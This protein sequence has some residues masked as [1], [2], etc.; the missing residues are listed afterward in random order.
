MPRGARTGVLALAL[1]ATTA[2][3]PTGPVAAIA[4]LAATNLGL[5]HCQYV[6]SVTQLSAGPGGPGD[7]AFTAVAALN[8][9]TSA[10]SLQSVDYPTY[11][12]TIVNATTG[13]VGI[14]AGADA[15]DASWDFASPLAP[16]PAGVTDAYTL[17][18]MSKNAAWTGAILTFATTNNAPCQYAAPCGDVVLSKAPVAD[19]TRQTWVV[20]AP[21]PAPA[22]NVSVSATVVNPAVNRRFMGCHSDYGFSQTPRG[23]TANLIYGSQF[24]AG[25]CAVPAW[26]PAIAGATCAGCSTG[27]DTA[28]SFSTRGSMALRL[29]AGSSADASVGVANRGLCGAGLALAAGQPYNA[30]FFIWSGGSPTGFVELRDRTT[31]ASLAKQTFTVVTTGPA[32]GSTWIEYTLTLTPSA[33][34]TCEGI[35][36]GSDPT[37][38]CGGQPSDAH[39]C[40]KCGGEFVIGL[41]TPGAIN[42]GH[43]TLTPGSW[44]LLQDKAGND[45]PVLKSGAAMLTAMGVTVM[46]SGGSVSQSMR[47]KDWRGP[48]WKRPSVAQTWGSSL[49]AGWG[50]FEV[51]DMCNA[52]DVQPIITLAYDVNDAGDFGDFVE[53]CWGD[54]TTT[55]WGRRRAEDGHPAVFNVTVVELGNEQYNPSFVEQV[56][57][58]EARVAAVGAPPFH[59]MFPQNGNL[60]AADAARAMALGLPLS[61][62]LPDLHVGAGGAVQEAAALFA[63][64]PIPGFDTGAINCEWAAPGAMLSTPLHSGTV[65]F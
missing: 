47:W 9:A 25:T 36:Y 65:G 56:A 63:A 14:A 23:F 11:Y 64:P 62:L 59:Y 21:A 35:P 48:A 19:A 20:G 32:W 41:E 58:M 8:G 29:G 55:T 51:I 18:S 4:P 28:S 60:N 22:V 6:A 46:R 1:A 17:Q 45:L 38:D 10:R 54:A 2:A 43:A 42:V 24:E 44:G 5:R 13:A 7:F 27:Y 30:T 40:V 53:Y 34:T 3:Q 39:V 16:P 52:L 26:T 50:P 37:I 61:R 31:G 57:A 49:L 33:G 12:L 15:N